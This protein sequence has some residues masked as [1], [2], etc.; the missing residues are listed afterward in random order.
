MACFD[1][2]YWGLWR[3]MEG[4]TKTGGLGLEASKLPKRITAVTNVIAIAHSIHRT[5]Q[6]DFNFVGW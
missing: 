1:T 4:N 6:N 3:R 2:L 5:F